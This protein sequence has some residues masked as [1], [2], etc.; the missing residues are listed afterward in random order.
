L[1][2]K[3]ILYILEYRESMEQIKTL[4]DGITGTKTILN[5]FQANSSKNGPTTYNKQILDPLTCMIKLCLLN[6]KPK[7]TKI[8]ISG[9]KISSQSPDMFQGATRWING[10]NRMD[11]HNL[12]NSI[13]RG[14]EWY[15]CESNS[16]IAN[17]FT[18]AIGGLRRLKESY[19]GIENTDIVCDAINHY[20]KIIEERLEKNIKPD[21]VKLQ[22]ISE[23][24]INKSLKNMWESDEIA[25][26]SSMLIL[27]KKKKYDQNEI[28]GII[29]AVECLLESKDITTHEIILKYTTTL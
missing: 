8:S 28:T 22:T 11:L 17:I 25:I 2:Y 7:G 12:C 20:I 9:N 16:N 1:I 5:S 14:V 24:N 19:Q 18:M 27:A 15:D 3:N 13:E 21:K 4:K 23:N 6:F 10:D 26:I 29:R